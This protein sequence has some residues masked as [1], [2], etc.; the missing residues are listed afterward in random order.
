MSTTHME[1]CLRNPAFREEEEVTVRD[2]RTVGFYNSAGVGRMLHVNACENL[3]EHDGMHITSEVRRNSR[4][5]ACRSLWQLFQEDN[6]TFHAKV[7]EPTQRT[8]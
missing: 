4:C 1:L 8:P 5:R 7:I 6:K 3:P 2:G